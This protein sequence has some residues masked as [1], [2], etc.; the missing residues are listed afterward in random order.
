MQHERYINQSPRKAL[1][2][3][4]FCCSYFQLLKAQ[5]RTTQS[6]LQAAVWPVAVG[7]SP[8]VA[9]PLLCRDNQAASQTAALWTRAACWPPC[10]SLVFLELYVTDG[11]QRPFKKD[12]HSYH[13][14]WTPFLHPGHRSMAA[15]SWGSSKR[16]DL[17]SFHA[18]FKG[19]IWRR[20]A[21]TLRVAQRPHP[22]IQ[23]CLTLRHFHLPRATQAV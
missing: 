19:V 21:Y 20:G 16:L 2:G 23:D 18:C 12:P 5:R 4:S 17:Q 22:Q 9:W 15:L 14:K 6:R 7:S 3:I 10:L 11:I 13:Q 8:R 1:G